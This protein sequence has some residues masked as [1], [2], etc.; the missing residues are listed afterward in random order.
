MPTECCFLAQTSLILKGLEALAPAAAVPI[1][2]SRHAPVEVPAN[3]MVTDFVFANLKADKIALIAPE[4]ASGEG[5]PEETITFGELH[6]QIRSFAAGLLARGLKKGDVVCIA[7][8]NCIEYVVVFHGVLSIGAILTTSNPGY[9]ASE[10]T[11]Q[12]T[13]S[14]AMMVITKGA[15]LLATV[16]EAV[17][18]AAGEQEIIYIG[19]E[20]ENTTPFAELL[21]AGPEGYDSQKEAIDASIDTTTHPVVYPY[22]SGTTGLPK[23]VM[24]SAHNLVSQL[25]QLKHPE[26]FPVEEDTVIDAVLPFYHIYGMVVIMN[27]GMLLNSTVVC[28]PK[29]DPKMY[30]TCTAKYKVPADD[31]HKCWVWALLSPICLLT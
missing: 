27:L 22:S 2:K 23:A 6:Q 30:M 19:G 16:T 28:Y 18:A 12:I 25:C 20:A 5:S 7:A 8:A 26:L 9:T 15:G 11:H 4:G 10:L 3:V 21:A 17:A 14:G 31:L 24:L 13:S 1:I 29:F